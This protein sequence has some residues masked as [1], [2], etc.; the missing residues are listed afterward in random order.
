[1]DEI[2][3]LA[4]AEGLTIDEAKLTYK[5]RQK[6]PATAFCGPNK[7]YPA[8]DAKHVRNGFVRLSTFGHRLSKEVRARIYRCLRRRAKRFGVEHNADTY[9]WKA[10]G[11]PNP[12]WRKR[13]NETV[14]W[15]LKKYGMLDEA[16]WIQKAI[17]HKGA[18]RK[19][20]GVKEGEVIPVS[21][22]QKII[23]TETGKTIKYKGKTI[24]VTTQLKRRALL[25]LRL[26]RMPKRGRK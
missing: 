23:N 25:A 9:R 3:F 5:A 2:E 17:K 13:I 15:Y 18:L 21:L 1:M 7:T 11:S 10:D 12:K 4:R 24:R 26:R 22:L 14:E 19:Q 16:Y 20:L 8:H 6:L